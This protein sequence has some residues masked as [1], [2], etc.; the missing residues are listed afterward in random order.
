[1]KP[2]MSKRIQLYLRFPRGFVV[3]GLQERHTWILIGGKLKKRPTSPAR[4][5]K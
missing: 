3:I 1:M 5:D 4:S 2:L